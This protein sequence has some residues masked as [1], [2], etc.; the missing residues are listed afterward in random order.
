MT[1]MNTLS[2]LIA[3]ISGA[4]GGVIGSG[5]Y[6]LWRSRRARATITVSPDVMGDRETVRRIIREMERDSRR[7]GM[8][9]R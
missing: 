1:D 2:F 3:V 9:G 7:F 4:V 6:Y 5:L 8:R